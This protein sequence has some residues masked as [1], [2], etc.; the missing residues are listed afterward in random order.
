M[1][2]IFALMLASQLEIDFEGALVDEYPD[3][4]QKVCAENDVYVGL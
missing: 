2:I 1:K 4:V 3:F